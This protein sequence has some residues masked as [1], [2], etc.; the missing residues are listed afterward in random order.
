MATGKCVSYLRVSTSRQGRSG[1]GLEA[2]RQAVADYLTG[3]QGP[4]IA[5]FVEI[6]SGKVNDRPALAKALA[7]CRLHGAK[8]VVA[9][10]DR[11]SRN[12]AF[13]LTLRDAGIEF[14]A[15][16]LPDANRMT[17]G[18]M[19]VIAEHERE[20]IGARTRAALQAAKMRGVRL[21][22]PGNL[23]VQARRLGAAVSAGV[24]S[25]RVDQRAADLAPILLE[26][27]AT[28]GASLRQIAAALDERG[29][30]A[31]RGGRW[32]AAQVQRLLERRRSRSLARASVPGSGE[33]PSPEGLL[34]Q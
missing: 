25:T 13:L 7:T 30:P 23:S 11:L 29:I 15:V 8:L 1:L 6:E 10:L 31:A 32:S 14:V 28:G 21:G 17:V 2:Q 33:E 12:A 27:Q 20:M 24:R 34:D 5:E 19:A 4:L 22:M 3:G 9:K 16:D 26:I 18:I